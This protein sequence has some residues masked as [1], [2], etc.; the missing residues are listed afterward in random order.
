MKNTIG[1]DNCIEIWKLARQCNISD[2]AEV[3]SEFIAK[4]FQSLQSEKL[5]NLSCE[6]MKEILY[7]NHKKVMF[8]S[9]LVTL[10]YGKRLTS[11]VV[12][13]Q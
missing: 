10:F 1:T 11:T 2:L 3:S 12:E 13:M 4:N 6:D 9:G 7:L 8:H 5:K